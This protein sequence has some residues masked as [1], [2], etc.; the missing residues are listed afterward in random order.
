MRDRQSMREERRGARWSWLPW[1]LAL[2]ISGAAGSAVAGSG[3]LGQRGRA[4]RPSTGTGGTLRVYCCW[5]GADYAPFHRWAR[6]ASSP[7]GFEP[8]LVA[9]VA[10]SMNKTVTYVEPRVGMLTPRVEMLTS[11]QADLVISTFSITPERARLVA[12]SRPYFI[13]GL[14][15]MVRAGA[16]FQSP[17]ELATK[18]LLVVSGTTGEAW[19][20]SNWPGATL[21]GP[22][23]SD[24][25]TAVASGQVDAY[26]NDRSHLV[27][28]SAGDSRVRVLPGYLT[29]EPWGIAAARG[30]A[31]LLGLVD[32]A[33]ASLEASGELAALQRR[34]LGP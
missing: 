24:E 21:V 2:L 14:G 5:R 11:G 27:N 15:A 31:A 29:R 12:F 18:R 30:N 4:E 10:V 8:D 3:S 16:P 13:D 1:T 17:A 6:G 32:A 9:R 19:V 28:L 33:L 23:V 7:V 26:M 25:R 22:I 34:W 20:R